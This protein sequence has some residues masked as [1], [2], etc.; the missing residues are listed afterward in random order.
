MTA[1]A[2]AP[3]LATIG[4]QVV[5]EGTA[6]SFTLSAS[7]PDG[8]SLTFSAAGLPTGATLDPVTGAFSWTP[9]Y[10]Q[11]GLYTLT[12]TVNDPT[13]LSGSETVTVTINDVVQNLGPLCSA[14]YPSISE[15][16]PPNHHQTQFV[17]IFGVTDPDNDHLTITIRQILQ[18]EP[19]NTNGDGTTWIDG[20][21]LGT[22]QAWVRAE[23]AGTK[24]VA[25]NGRVY[26][27]FFDASDRRG[28]SCTG[29]VKIGVPH[30]QGKGPAVDDGK[31]Y[32]STVANGPCLNCNQ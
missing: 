10:E 12:F 14:A 26:E 32:N 1:V 28:K 9:T 17:S 3:I 2:D 13:N 31:R 25:G 7:D 27:T 21:G 5:A 15:I 22:A 18:D 20:G 30:D 19:T 24:K 29:S 4:N 23:S 8:E 6:L 16:W 11:A